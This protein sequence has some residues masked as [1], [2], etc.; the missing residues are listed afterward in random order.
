MSFLCWPHGDNN[1]N[2]NQTAIDSGYL[3]TTTGKAKDTGIMD[4]KRIPERMG[5][6]FSN[7]YKKQ[8]SIFKLKALSGKLLHRELLNY[9]RQLN[10]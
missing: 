10:H 3:M 4:N 9:Y 8:K 7:W 5:L 2:L 1:E 6:D